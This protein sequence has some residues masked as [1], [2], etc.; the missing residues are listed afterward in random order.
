MNLNYGKCFMQQISFMDGPK[1]NSIDKNIE[2][3]STSFFL[4]QNQL[5]SEIKKFSFH[6]KASFM[7]KINNF[8]RFSAKKL[9]LSYTF[10]KWDVFL[11]GFPPTLQSLKLSLEGTARV[12]DGKCI[13]HK[14]RFANKL[15]FLIKLVII[16]RCARDA[17]DRRSQRKCT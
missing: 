6:L 12:P 11:I 10:L 2:A 4:C 3:L 9:K 8:S 1:F 17:Y 16:L 7:W 13:K 15:I 5:A 14:F